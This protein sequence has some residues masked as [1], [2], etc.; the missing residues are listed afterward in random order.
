M[1]GNIRSI[2]SMNKSPICTTGN[3]IK[4]FRKLKK[5]IQIKTILVAT[6]KTILALWPLHTRI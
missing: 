6:Y 4:I 5:K 2:F 3:E 1:T